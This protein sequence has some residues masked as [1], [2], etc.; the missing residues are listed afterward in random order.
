MLVEDALEE[1]VGVVVELRGA[2]W[3]DLYPG[4]TQTKI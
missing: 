2:V 1:Q 4:R 3:G